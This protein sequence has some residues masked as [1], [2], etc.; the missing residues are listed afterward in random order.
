MKLG[1][2]VHENRQG[3][4]VMNICVFKGG[5]QLSGTFS[6]LLTP[7][8][9][10]AQSTLYT[11]HQDHHGNEASYVVGLLRASEVLIHI[12]QAV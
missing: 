5:F 1:E 8:T 7:T 11:V 4:V 12:S 3:S 2:L 10:L 6:V 9:K